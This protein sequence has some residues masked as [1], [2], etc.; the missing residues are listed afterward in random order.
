MLIAVTHETVFSYDR[1]I[2]ETAMELRLA[3]TSD[4][5]QLCRQFNLSLDP[6]GHLT[7][8]TDIFGNV[9]HFYNYRPSHQRVRIVAE[10]VVETGLG[11]LVQGAE[12]LRYH[13]LAFDGP[14]LDLDAVGDAAQNL[15]PVNPGDSTAVEDALERLTWL[16]NQRFRYQPG[17][18]NAQSTI[19]DLVAT[20]AGVCQDFAHFWIAVCRKLGIPARYVSGYLHRDA[21][22]DEVD[23][24]NGASHGWAEAWI[25]GQGWRGYDPTNPLTASA[26]RVKIAVGRDYR[27]VPPT[28]GVF[29]GPAVEH[30]AVRVRTRSVDPVG[31]RST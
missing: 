2:A 17:V 14:V 24:E 22:P 29:L 1:L 18:T 27:D 20:G 8:R 6:V 15:G 26:R 9:I 3:P 4:A 13:F 31:D 7:T 30:V 23:S 21:P 16:V 12:L 19:V 10:S 11:G 5:T 28:K 25:P